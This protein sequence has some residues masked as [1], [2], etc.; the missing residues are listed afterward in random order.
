MTMHAT[1]KSDR[2]RALSPES[3]YGRLRTP[4]QAT[5]YELDLLT[6]GRVNDFAYPTPP[7]HL[8]QETHV[9]LLTISKTALENLLTD[10]TSKQYID[11]WVVK[12]RSGSSRHANWRIM[13]RTFEPRRAETVARWYKTRYPHLEVQ[14]TKEVLTISAEPSRGQRPRP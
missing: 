8:R 9:K 3:Q 13:L 12:Q 2:R 11:V 6:S 10:P 1:T 4:Y 5:Q 7:S 14:L